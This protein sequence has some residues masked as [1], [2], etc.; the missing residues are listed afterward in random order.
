MF[1]SHHCTYCGQ[2]IGAPC[3]APALTHGASL[4]HLTDGVDL[5]RVHANPG[6]EHLQ[7][8]V[9]RVHHKHDP[10]HREGGLSN[11]GGHHTLA[12]TV[13]CLLEDLGL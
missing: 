9:A 11:V 13:R 12:H 6:V 3:P 10:V 8:A 2:A 1:Q 5:Q 7:L 4:T